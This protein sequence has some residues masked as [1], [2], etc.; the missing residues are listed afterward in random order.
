MTT[1][2]RLGT[3]VCST[4]HGCFLRLTGGLI[5]ATD[6]VDTNAY[7]NNEYT[8][9]MN[10]ALVNG[11]SGFAPPRPRRRGRTGNLRSYAQGRLHERG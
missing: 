5:D 8:Q 10:Q 11:P 6:A 9:F 3:G 4:G 7:A 2:L 1:C